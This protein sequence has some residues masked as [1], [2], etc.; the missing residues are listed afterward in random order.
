MYRNFH[1]HTSTLQ[2]PILKILYIMQ[3]DVK[4]NKKYSVSALPIVLFLK[5]FL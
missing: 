2:K 5:V 1:S 4:K 3:I